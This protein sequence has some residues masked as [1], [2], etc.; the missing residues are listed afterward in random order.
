MKFSYLVAS[1]TLAAY[2]HTKHDE[3]LLKL[4]L[5]PKKVSIRAN[6]SS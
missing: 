5:D 4:D 2:S 1:F 3:T 6:P